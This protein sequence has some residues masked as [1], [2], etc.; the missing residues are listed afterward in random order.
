M[1][2]CALA[3]AVVLATGADTQAAASVLTHGSRR[4]HWVALTFDDGWSLDHCERI[5]A[6]LRGRH[7]RATFLPYGAAVLSS[8]KRWKALLEGFPVANHTLSHPWLDRL[9]APGIHRQ[10]QR[11]ERLLV[12][13]LDRPIL[14]LLR[15]PYGAYDAEVLRVAGSLGYRVVLWDTSGCDTD[16][17]ATVKSVI[18][19]ARSGVNGSIVLMHCGP[20]VTPRA[21]GAIIDSYRARGYR[22]VGLGKMFGR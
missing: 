18:R 22:L 11:N 15:P 3:L 12:R 8:P 17:R 14:R 16:S 9:D 2:I 20:A 6:I 13:I 7:A 5:S 21:L 19:H 4:E 10:I 1:A